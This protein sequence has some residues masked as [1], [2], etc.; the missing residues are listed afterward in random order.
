MS[1]SISF[2]F[3]IAIAFSFFGK[4]WWVFDLASH[5]RLQYAV[6]SVAL[7]PLLFLLKRRGYAA[8]LLCL[9]IANAVALVPFI[10]AKTKNTP[11]DANTLKTLFL[12]VNTQLGN[13]ARVVDLILE[14]SPDFFVLQEINRAWKKDVS[15]LNELYPHQVLETREDNFGIGLF[16]KHPIISSDMLYLDNYGFPS[17]SA[18]LSTSNTTLR[19]LSTHT[20]PPRDNRY[21]KIRNEQLEQLAAHIYKIEG[22]VILL[23]DLNTTV[24]NYYFQ[25]LLKDSGLINSY[26]QHGFLSTWPNFLPGMGIQIDH[27]LHSKEISMNDIYVGPKVGSDHLP[28]IAEFIIIP[29]N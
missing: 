8:I 16:S 10:P 15:A 17:I 7:I 5:F 28:L 26:K 1:G 22:P 29:S 2:I 3:V 4:Y 18:T 14:E 21:T 6:G 24:Y 27:I 11:E 25:K 23:G 20:L 13:P 19:I 12:N 9:S